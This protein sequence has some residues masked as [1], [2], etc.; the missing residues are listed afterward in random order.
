MSACVVILTKSPQPGR[1]KTRLIPALGAE[2][3]ARFH[4]ALVDITLDKVRRSGLPAMVSLAGSPDEPFAASI[5]AQGFAIEPQVS[6]DLG[7]RL[8]HAMRGP[9]RRIAIG[10]DC[11]LFSPQ[12][13]QDAAERSDTLVIGPASDGGY[14][15]LATDT[16]Q[17]HLFTDIPWS[18][19]QTCSVT[20]QRAAEQGL[21]VELAPEQDDIDTPADLQRLL[22]DPRCP[23]SL[24]ALAPR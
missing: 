3:A 14:W 8:R 4:R 2:G 22:R 20:L 1:V 12:T 9:G 19:A 24:Q 15:M 17:D 21:R 11:P 16:P 23:P 6:G 7:A 18:T 5:R 13:L 10:T